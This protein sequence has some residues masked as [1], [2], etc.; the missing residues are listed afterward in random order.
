MTDSD[1]NRETCQHN[2]AV[3]PENERKK[4]LQ[5]KGSENR[6]WKRNADDRVSKFEDS[7]TNIRPKYSSGIRNTEMS[8]EIFAP[9]NMPSIRC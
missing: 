9:K 2:G 1:T 3:R 5:A 7:P 4:K 6:Q 8:I